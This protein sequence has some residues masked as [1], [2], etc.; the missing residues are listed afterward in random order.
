MNMNQTVLKQISRY[1]VTS[2][3]ARLSEPHGYRLEGDTVHLQAR[4]TVL[5][6]AAHESTWALQLWACPTKPANARDL[7]GHI[8]AEV[9][10]PPM[11]EAADETE[12]LDMHAFAIPPAG[13]EQHFMALVLATGKSGKFDEIHDLA[14]YSRPQRFLQP[15]ISG[16]VGYRIDGNR[17]RLS[18]ER[19]Q[20]PRDAGNSSGTLALEL[21]AVASPYTGGSFQG[22]PLA[23]VAIG[24]LSGQAELAAN[25]FDLPFTRPPAGDWH[26]VLMLREW[27]SAGYVT[28]DFTNFNAAV[29]YRLPEV[30]T[31]AKAVIMATNQAA[32]T[33][34]EERTRSNSAGAVQPRVESKPATT[35]SAAPVQADA[36][37]KAV[38]KPV[39]STPPVKAAPVVP[40]LVSVNTAAEEELAAV[41]G[42]T[43][44][45]ARA[46]AKKRPFASLDDLR[47]IKGIGEK[48]LNS[49][50]SR[51]KL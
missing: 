25:T 8:M 40:R 11:S 41:E 29:S 32:P 16:T 20:N 37:S 49:I 9:A 22:V 5:D 12:H 42:L 48:L 30:T 36:V 35:L 17:V 1:S 14:V 3:L 39:A 4:L 44:K 6:Q 7:V 13:T 19:I 50:R 47:G 38:Q 33:T 26:L 46:I 21:W 34:T 18:V 10:L 27:T 45:L 51:L 23:G 15:K 24:S 43:P 28:R 2:A 31:P